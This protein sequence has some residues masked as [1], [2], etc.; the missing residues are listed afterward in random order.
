MGSL[1]LS[2]GTSLQEKFAENGPLLSA[3][4]FA[5]CS[6]AMTL[7]NK[8][9]LQTY[10][11]DGP[12]TLTAAQSLATII[13]LFVAARIWP[14][15]ITLPAFTPSRFIA[16][17]PLSIV[18]VLKLSTSM[19]GLGKTNVPMFTALRQTAVLFV[20]V[21]ERIL[22]GHWP[23]SNH[24]WT[25]TALICGGALLAAM[26][27][28][29]YDPQGYAYIF[30]ANLTASLYAVMINLCKRSTGLD[31]VGLLV[32][33]SLLSFPILM[34]VAGALTGDFERATS[35]TLPEGKTTLGF[36]FVFASAVLLSTA[37]NF[38]LFSVTTLTNA[39]TK[40]VISGLKS[41]GTSLLGLFLFTDYHYRFLNAVGLVVSFAGGIYYSSIS[42][43]KG[44]GS[45][46]GSVTGSVEPGLISPSNSTTNGAGVGSSF[47][48][49]SSVAP[50]VSGGSSVG[51][52]NER[53]AA[54]ALPV[55]LPLLVS[56]GPLG[57]VKR[58]PSSAIDCSNGASAVTTGRSAGLPSAE[59]ISV[60]GHSHST[61]VA[62]N[63]TTITLADGASSAQSAV[64]SSSSSSSVSPTVR[65]FTP[66]P[67]PSQ[68]RLGT[69]HR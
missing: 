8:S 57:A 66:L 14:Q 29:N 43:A 58:K 54:A 17:L 30:A 24:V 37:L 49:S 27:D 35:Y 40:T 52:S 47:I 61:T 55:G 2:G 22:L 39:T 45:N 38:A 5:G 25:S 21:E 59:A 11:F 46:P 41:V 16:V 1:K 36:T 33:N 50:S 60:N 28:A 65:T 51:T 12:L 44:G 19:L 13:I 63:T 42:F 56:S 64:S 32:Y 7:F 26:Q 62:S 68:T 67:T 31:V 69:H 20:I 18:F 10:R 9:I 48:A 4:A 3:L 34:A 15:K 23:S 6:V 53:L